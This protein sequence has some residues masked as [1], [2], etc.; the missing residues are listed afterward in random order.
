MRAYLQYVF[1]RLNAIDKLLCEADKILMIHFS[2]LSASD[3]LII[4]AKILLFIVIANES[5]KL[6]V[7]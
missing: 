7:F 1:H 4:N 3:L 5:K 6:L 2:F